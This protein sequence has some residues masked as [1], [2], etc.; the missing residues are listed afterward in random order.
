MKILALELSSGQGSVAWLENDREPFVHSFANDRKHSGLFFENLQRCA[1]EFGAPDV[2][3]VGLGPGSY[4]GVRIAI[5]A[6]VGLRTAC[7][8]KL[9]G[10]PSVC[11]IETAAR[12]YCVIGDARRESFFFGRVRDGRLTEVPSLHSRAELEMKIMELSVPLY[13]SEPLPQFPQAALAYPSAR[14]LAEVGRDQ[15]GEIADTRSLEPIYLRE[16]HIT[17]PKVSPRV[18]IKQ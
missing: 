13:A 7:S 18:A 14:R 9:V 5:A 1:Q 6:A 10:I 17:M 15:A 16:P 4:A 12:E 11:A 3:V 2:I 8:A